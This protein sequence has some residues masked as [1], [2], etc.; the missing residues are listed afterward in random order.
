MAQEL[1]SGVGRLGGMQTLEAMTEIKMIT[2]S[3]KPREA[4]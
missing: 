3:A 2:I 1:R 4:A